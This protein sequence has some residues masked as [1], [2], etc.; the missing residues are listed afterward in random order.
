MGTVIYD[1]TVKDMNGFFEMNGSGHLSVRSNEGAA[2]QWIEK[3]ATLPSP[4]YNMQPLRLAQRMVHMD[5]QKRLTAPQVVSE[6]I[7]FPEEPNLFC[8]ACCDKSNDSTRQL[9]YENPWPDTDAAVAASLLEQDPFLA[10]EQDVT[11]FGASGETLGTG[12]PDTDTVEQDEPTRHADE[13]EVLRP[14]TLTH[15]NWQQPDFEQIDDGLT[16]RDIYPDQEQL[17]AH[18]SARQAQTAGT[19]FESN[20]SAVK[21]V[22]IEELEPLLVEISTET[23]GLSGA[24]AI[25]QQDSQEPSSTQRLRKASAVCKWPGCA[26]KRDIARIFENNEQLHLHYRSMHGVHDFAG[27]CLLDSGRQACTIGRYSTS[28]TDRLKFVLADKPLR[29]NNVNGEKNTSTTRTGPGAKETPLENQFEK[30]PSK[31]EQKSVSWNSSTE[32]GAIEPNKTQKTQKARNTSR[33]DTLPEGK[34]PEPIATSNVHAPEQVNIAYHEIMP[35]PLEEPLM[36]QSVNDSTGAKVFGDGSRIPRS[37]RV[38]S[39]FLASMNRFTRIEVDALTPAARLSSLVPPPLFVYGSLMFP[40]I[41]RARAESY[42]GAEGVY[43]ELHQR[44][45]RTDAS[46]WSRMNFSLQH[47]AE[48]M[49]PAILK[50]YDIW[51]PSGL[52][53]PAIKTAEHTRHI[54]RD[55]Q[56]DDSLRYEDCRGEV[57][58]F[59]IF[60]LSEEALKCLDHMFCSDALLSLYGSRGSKVDGWNIFQCA[61]KRK[62]VQVDIGLKGGGSMNVNAVTYTWEGVTSKLSSVWK[63]NDFTKSRRFQKLS[64]IGDQQ[65]I[66]VT[67]EEKL[68]NTMGITFV[69]GGDV[70]CDAIMRDDREELCRLVESGENVNAPCRTYGSAIQAAAAEGKLE[71]VE[72]LLEKD[73]DVN[74]RG[75][76]YMHPLIAATVRGREDVAKVLIKAGADVLADGGQYVSPL[77]QAVD[78]TDPEL[79]LLL[80]EKGAWLSKDYQELLDL[81]AERGNREITRML[82]QYDVRNLHL[83]RSTRSRSSIND[84]DSDSDHYEAGQ[85]DRRVDR[86]YDNQQVEMKASNVL[87]KVLWEIA[88]LK[89]QRGKWTGIKGVRVMR[90]AMSAGVSETLLEKLRP[91]LQSSYQLLDF[92][93]NATINP[94]DDFMPPTPRRALE[95]RSRDQDVAHTERPRRRTEGTARGVSY[96][97]GEQRSNFQRPQRNESTSLSLQPPA[98]SRQD[99]RS[100]SEYQASADGSICVSCDGRGGRRGTGRSCTECAGLGQRRVSTGSLPGSSRCKTCKGYGRVFSERDRCRYCQGEAAANRPIVDIPSYP[101]PPYTSRERLER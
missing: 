51:R 83:V 90:A 25:G 12:M 49:T 37:S 84:R 57:R 5:P 97:Y 10:E 54:C 89:G 40:G 24:T 26:E 14:S 8:G 35:E 18:E 73:A 69:M 61:F 32:E 59:L 50:G 3:L 4:S 88:I 96:T 28:E 45:L 100:D 52:S 47:A 58:G 63:I 22:A 95:D 94:A 79:A 87:K 21:H 74:A 85:Y 66:W 29:N 62:N 38:P 86:R 64:G 81:A 42:I 13:E 19:S 77:Y 68:A 2:H 92:L 78:F 56:R 67:E 1:K 48:Q 20:S 30:K 70:L 36:A 11:D 9:A 80:L 7:D 60:G 53:C 41:L 82:E 98:R 101:P 16:L 76:Q 55:V 65:S 91:H 43:S 33:F 15:R 44:R 23:S 93:K 17:I 34:R 39:Y 27:S 99:G 46:D 72:Y 31:A 6:I 75:G 71:I